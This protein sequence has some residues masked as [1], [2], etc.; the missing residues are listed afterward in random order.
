MKMRKSKRFETIG[1]VAVLALCCALTASATQPTT[2][3][4]GGNFFGHV[5][6]T[7]VGGVSVNANIY[8]SK[9]AVYLN[10]GPENQNGAS[11]PVGTYYFQVTDPNGEQLLS[12]DDIHCR[13]VQVTVVTGNVNRITGHVVD[14]A[15]TSPQATHDN[16]PINFAN[17][18]V[19]V[20]V[21]PAA[22]RNS[23]SL[24][25]GASYDSGNWCD[26]TS[27]GGGEYKVWLTPI[28]KY[29]PDHCAN[30][31]FC[32]NDSKTDN[33][34]ITPTNC[35]DTNSCP[36]TP[37]IV[38]P[39][40]G[41]KFYDSN[42]NGVQDDGEPIIDGWQVRAVKS[43]QED[44]SIISALLGGANIPINDADFT[45]PGTN[46]PYGR[47][48]Q[49]TANGTYETEALQD[50]NAP[51][52]FQTDGFYQYKDLNAGGHYSVCEIIPKGAASVFPAGLSSL[53]GQPKWRPTSAAES[54]D[55]WSPNNSTSFGNVCTGSGG[56]L[57]LGFW[58]NTNG[59]GVM[60]GGAKV[61]KSCTTAADTSNAMKA[62]LKFLA[63]KN[64]VDPTGGPAFNLVNASGQYID[65]Y[66]MGYCNFRTWLLG[67]T[68]TNAAY[69]LS[70]Q[71]AAME[72][73]V[74]FGYVNPNSLIYAPGTIT[75]NPA[76]FATVQAVMDEA[77]NVLG[78][79]PIAIAGNLLNSN[80]TI[81]SYEVLIKNALDNANNNLGFVQSGP[82][83]CPI[84]YGDEGTILTLNPKNN[85]CIPS[86]APT[87]TTSVLQPLP[88]NPT[89]PVGDCATHPLIHFVCSLVGNTTDPACT[90]P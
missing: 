77:V 13:E 57:T 37:T 24:N 70:V 81:K 88:Q 42:T 90:N 15:C 72:L 35:A 29:D 44:Q 30:H 55:H 63:Y 51:V 58:S 83:S 17:G 5:Y 87:G 14:A 50:P 59:E 54:L 61:P 21:C 9:T 69:M 84:A 40:G 8:P 26:T 62:T 66:T 7:T 4:Q 16:S 1:V 25:N 20:Q 89:V 22:S 41:Y 49:F 75:A 45:I 46:L 78:T 71:L 10:G 73:N 23:D 18:S 39:L 19:P 86:D 74:R 48:F 36:P 32:A 67:A 68:S 56:G 52:T 28:N 64:G 34:K 33:F 27:N 31:G 79:N 38:W 43:C 53:S 85:S 3:G 11:L 76:G 82:N 65:P 47:Q 2:T 6:T 80:V 60:A 12:A